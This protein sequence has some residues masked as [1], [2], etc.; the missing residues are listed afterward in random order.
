MMAEND[1]EAPDENT[2]EELGLNFEALSDK[3]E[4]LTEK[5]GQT[6]EIALAYIIKTMKMHYIAEFLE[7]RWMTLL[8]Y[9]KRSLKKGSLKEKQLAATAISIFSISLGAD[10]EKVFKDVL[11][12]LEEIIADHSF[13]S[14]VRS[15]AISSLS[16]TCFVANL[17]GYITL[18][19]LDKLSAWFS[20]HRASEDLLISSLRSWTLLATTVSSRWIHDSAIPKELKKMTKLLMHTSVDVRLAVGELIAFLFEVERTLEEDDFDLYKF[21]QYAQIDIDALL[22]ILNELTADRSKQRAKKDKA[23][24]KA[25]F[26]DVSSTVEDGNKPCE[27]LSFKHQK[28]RFESWSKIRQLNAFRD[29]LGEGLQTHFENNELLQQIFGFSIDVHMK[30]QQMSAI[31]KRLYMS[32]S[33]HLSKERARN[34]KQQRDLKSRGTTTSNEEN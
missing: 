14:S 28:F 33:S 32:S 4:E 26:K 6:R 3:I 17:D 13:A 9:F 5:S 21:G 20:D 2:S 18:E 31:E 10:S 12:T 29:F 22:N 11:S 19:C 24:Q 1:H 30:R 23:K 34:M 15:A 7:E 25:S 8:E 27:I 16:M